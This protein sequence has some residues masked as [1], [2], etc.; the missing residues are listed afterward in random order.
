MVG[1]GLPIRIMR[2]EHNR[3][4]LWAV[5]FLC[6]VSAVS[7]DNIIYLRSGLT[8]TVFGPGETMVAYGAVYQ[9]T[10]SAPGQPP[11]APDA[12]SSGNVT[13]NVST[14]GGE[15]QS[16]TTL[17]I[18]SQGIFI[19]YD[20]DSAPNSPAIIAPSSAGSYLVITTYN[21]NGTRWQNQQ[22]FIVESVQVDELRLVPDKASYYG[23]QPITAT[24]QAL[25]DSGT[26]VVGVANISIN[27]TM[28]NLQD[29]V[30]GAFSNCS[31]T[32]SALTDADGYCTVTVN[33]PAT[34]G[35]Y[36]LEANSF[37]ASTFI[38]V[39]PF[40]VAVRLRDSTGANLKGLFTVGD[41]GK[42]EVAVTY[43]GTSPASGAYLFNGTIRNPD[44]RVLANISTTI[45][46]SSNAY[47]GS[48]QFTVDS[49]W[50]SG[51]YAADVD[52]YGTETVRRQG[53]FRVRTWSFTLAK[54]SSNSGFL[55]DYRGFADANL[56]F[57]LTP[58][59]R[60]NGSMIVNLNVTRDVNITLKNKLGTTK[61]GAVPYWDAT[62]GA[63]GCYTFNLT[64][65]NQT[66]AY[67]LAVAVNWSS[68][69][70][71]QER[72]ITVTD[73]TATAY[74]ANKDGE[75]QDQ[76]GATDL[77]YLKV[78]AKNNTGTIN[79]TD[80]QLSRL[81]YEDGAA[82]NITLRAWPQLNASDINVSWAFNGSKQMIALNTPL[83]GGLYTAEIYVNNRSAKA[84]ATFIYAPYELCAAAVDG[85]GQ[86]PN[87]VWQFRTSDTVYFQLKVTQ[88]THSSGSGRKEDFSEGGGAGFGDPMGG[89][90]R[91]KKDRGCLSY[92]QEQSSAQQAIT[93]ATITVDRVVN[94][95]NGK[96]T[97]LNLTASTCTSAD[98]NGGYKC[99][100]KPLA[101]W[102]GGS[103]HGYI[104]VTGTDGTVA[105]GDGT[106]EARNFFFASWPN[107]WINKA[108]DTVNLSIQMY[109]PG[110]GWWSG[111]SGGMSGTVTI[112]RVLYLGSPGEWLS[113]PV[114]A[115]YNTT[116]LSSSS[117]SS[118]SGSVVL[119]PARLTDGQWKSGSYKAVLKGV[120]DSS[121]TVDYGEAMFE[122]RQWFAS[123]M[124]TEYSAQSQQWQWKDSF[125]L[126]DNVTLFVD[127]K[128]AGNWQSKQSLG[129]DVRV[130]VRK[131][132]DF[133][134]WP[135]QELDP[136]SYSV[137]PIVV[138]ASSDFWGTGFNKSQYV[139]TIVPTAGAWDSGFYDVVL[140]LNGTETGFGWFNAVAFF[141]AAQLVD[142]AGADAWSLR[143]ADPLRLR[144]TT[145]RSP[146]YGFVPQDQLLNTT[147]TEVRLHSFDPST[148]TPQEFSYPDDINISATD[149]NGSRVINITRDDGSSWPTGF[150]DGE[151]LLQNAQGESSSA[152]IFFEVRSFSVNMG[153]MF[154]QVGRTAIV[155]RNLTINDPAGPGTVLLG[156]YSIQAVQ[157]NNWGMG[158]PDL[159]TNFTPAGVFDGSKVQVNITP[160]SLAGGKWPLGNND[161]TIIIRNDDTGDTSQAWLNFQVQSALVNVQTNTPG[162][163]TAGNVSITVALSSA[164]DQIMLQSGVQANLSRI[165]SYDSRIG[166]V[167]F[168]VQGCSAQGNC[169]ITDTANVTV[170]PPAGG[171]PEGWSSLQ[172]MF[173]EVDDAT[174]T[175]EASQWIN[176]QVRQS[177]WG[178]MFPAN[179][180]F[181]GYYEPG[182]TENASLQVWLFDANGQEAAGEVTGVQIAAPD[183]SCFQDFCRS[184]ADAY[185]W[186][187][188]GSA[189]AN[190]SS[191]DYLVIVPDGQWVQGEYAVRLSVRNASTGGSGTIR[192]YFRTTDRTPPVV[193]ID[194]PLN[195]STVSL[196]VNGSL[197]INVSTDKKVMCGYFITNLNQTYY[198]FQPLWP[199]DDNPLF[200]HH[201]QPE[202][203][204]DNMTLT[205]RCEDKDRNFQMRN[206][207]FE[208]IGTTGNCTLLG[209]GAMP[210]MGDGGLSLQFEEPP[211]GPPMT[212]QNSTVTIRYH[213]DGPA[214]NISGVTL[215]MD[216]G[217][218]INFSEENVT[219]AHTF[220]GLSD[221]EHVIH[222]WLLDPDG[223][224]FTD[225]PMYRN[226]TFVVNAS[227][228]AGSGA[229]PPVNIS[230]SYPTEGQSISSVDVNAVW[231]VTGNASQAQGVILRLDSDEQMNVSTNASGNQSFTASPGA[232]V[233]HAWLADSGW[234]PLGGVDQYGNV[235]FTVSIA[236]P[237]L[238]PPN[239]SIAYP[240][241]GAILSG[242]DNVT[243]IYNATG[244]LTLVSAV[245]LRVDAQAVRN[246]SVMNA[247][248]N[249]TSLADGAH[250]AVLWLGGEDAQPLQYP[251]AYTNVTFTVNLSGGQGQQSVNV[252]GE[253]R[254]EGNPMA[255]NIS[256]RDTMVNADGNGTFRI[257]VEAQGVVELNVTYTNMSVVRARFTVDGQ[258]PF[259][260][261]SLVP[262]DIV[263]AGVVNVTNPDTS[264]NH[265]AINL[266]VNSSLAFP[267]QADAIIFREA[268]VFGA[269]K[270]ISLGADAITTEGLADTGGSASW[271][272]GRINGTMASSWVN[273]TQATVL[274]VS[275]ENWFNASMGGP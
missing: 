95:Q 184:Y 23:G 227:G 128:N 265:T 52:V 108:N 159:I 55:Q 44:G 103:Y 62:C 271:Y 200:F 53:S 50:S 149:I 164:Q 40:D 122:I 141:S 273:A 155:G 220:T 73:Q 157:R 100:V 110:Q 34:S 88:A 30:L 8:K 246:S 33:A 232:H 92:G 160:A 137:T 71:Q 93:N 106:F 6:C 59:Y 225:F 170:V 241:E 253:V 125:N 249:L 268:V 176:F 230:I 21:D 201:R 154:E 213:R 91:G 138:N 126:R 84:K 65:P 221:G 222:G 178:N 168:Y 54:A 182:V 76:F 267:V 36:R 235:S 38:K 240:A 218:E 94:E 13:I 143:S 27:A 194:F 140:D 192:G 224:R 74:S 153:W 252:T 150:Y 204:D 49:D 262:I 130:S 255:G 75:Q 20:A 208:V 25:R 173:S 7:A 3:W 46:N 64:A 35:A 42:V 124:P 81:T 14:T 238:P 89:G 242:Q 12:V 264:F 212:Y 186:T 24:I 250:V 39:V 72:V 210:P 239:I 29:T 254:L 112:D 132:M 199:Q 228:D 19:S 101:D 193:T 102:E 69:L 135:P 167:Q 2:S 104:T 10:Q 129:G 260:N 11:S 183:P 272:R 139:L 202:I 181:Q 87:F 187:I 244:N 127:I 131:I 223:V 229:Q 63:A 189:D 166:D 37:L 114:D 258:A 195:A 32:Q 134:S 179:S 266:T 156:N 216:S 147:I 251:S 97:P 85:L 144:L 26:A 60:A 174:S 116:G 56:S 5:L 43:N 152:R 45:L 90:M 17:N 163:T 58:V 214:E 16:L 226:R 236:G 121:G 234:S 79:I 48:Y 190:M 67:T 209:G 151:V 57:Q 198:R 270:S 245:F 96:D 119:D 18:S 47:I 177:Y 31:Q 111:S 247:T 180:Q 28:R 148:F 158:Q 257:Q 196:P 77:V 162:V 219:Q 261:V 118:G 215:R 237:V 165:W 185:G 243:L 113:A 206:I 109:Q 117:V 233:L 145:S 175:F 203:C 256:W 171:W 259:L 191:G 136:S 9:A 133:T 86:N 146:A 80:A 275:W 107:R 142:S 248:F 263:A 207:A 120:D 115:G 98:N 274:A 123:S 231:N 78:S 4:G 15:T 1:Q 197:D 83:R 217:Q 70:Q 169:Q 205:V 41:A 68:E 22:S 61:A 66:G 188:T 172:T 105:K 82:Q 161:I 269:A 99:T 211:E 51:A